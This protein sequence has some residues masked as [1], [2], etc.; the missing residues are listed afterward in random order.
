LFENSLYHEYAL[1][2]LNTLGRKVNAQFSIIYS[3]E[4][5]DVSPKIG[6]DYYISKMATINNNNSYKT[7]VVKNCNQSILKPYWDLAIPMR[8]LKLKK[9]EVSLYAI[10]SI[11]S[12][13]T[14]ICHLVTVDT[15]LR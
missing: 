11:K 8:V 7:L 5:R 10:K 14:N 15:F 4:N 3:D 9:K 1:R 13:D 2:E 12:L 6:L